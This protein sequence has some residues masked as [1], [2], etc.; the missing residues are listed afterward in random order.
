MENITFG[1]NEPNMMLLADLVN[2][3][4]TEYDVFSPIME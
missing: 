4:R 2:G 1:A 3:K